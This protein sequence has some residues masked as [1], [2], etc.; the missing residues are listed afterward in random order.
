MYIYYF[1]EMKIWKF[2]RKFYISIFKYNYNISYTS[3]YYGPV[4]SPMLFITIYFLVFAFIVYSLYVCVRSIF[5]GCCER[6]VVNR[7]NGFEEIIVNVD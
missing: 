1:R 6:T 7:N 5:G 2:L 3:I 4:L